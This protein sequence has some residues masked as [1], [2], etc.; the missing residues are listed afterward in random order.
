MSVGDEK[1]LKGCKYLYSQQM[2]RGG[3][4]RALKTQREV[5][6]ILCQQ[7]VPQR[8]RASEELLWASP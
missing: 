3:G 8:T 7:K 4:G 5:G 2:G 1:H 6:E